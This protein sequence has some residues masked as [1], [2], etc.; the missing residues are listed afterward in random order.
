MKK[1]LYE[2]LT[3]VVQENLSEGQKNLLEALDKSE[4]FFIDNVAKYFWE[5]EQ[6]IWDIKSDFP[7]LA[8][9]F[10]YFFM[11][12]TSPSRFRDEQGLHIFDDELYKIGV[13]FSAFENPKEEEWKWEYCITLFDEGEFDSKFFPRLLPFKTLLRL[14]R[15]GNPI[16]HKESDPDPLIHLVDESLKD[17]PELVYAFCT[18]LLYPA[19]LAICFLHC[20]NVKILPRGAGTYKGKRNRHGPHIKYHVLNIEPMKE[21]LRTEGKSEE[22]GLKLALH[23][24]RGHFKDFREGKGLFGRYKDIYWW[25]SQVRGNMKEGIVNKDYRIGTGL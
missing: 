8:P 7:N 1:T 25:D 21:T 3:N 6:L 9:P 11:E 13:L 23:I 12:F 15:C 5:S 24:C 10:P 20:K 4:I 18:N 17:T 22:T 19:L 2:K 16:K 14:D